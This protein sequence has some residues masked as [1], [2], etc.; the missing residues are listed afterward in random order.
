MNNDW[1][2]DIE[3]V[4]EKIRKNSSILSEEHKHTYFRLKNTLQY[5][6]LPLI[7]I[8]GIN[9][10]ISVG[11]QQYLE[12]PTISG[13]TCVL[14]LI[15]SII[16]SIEL[17]LAI[18]KRVEAELISSREYYLLT[19]DIQKT[20]LLNREH[21]PLPAKEYLE[22]I[23][24][25]YIKLTESSNLVKKSIKDALSEVTITPPSTPTRIQSVLGTFRG[26]ES[27]DLEWGLSIV[28]P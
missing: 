11:L 4:L 21:R 25:T 1:T 5:F 14:S 28:H 6:R 24:N 7:V 15:C 17:F 20:L 3:N 13:I 2:E 12:Q 22:K 19:I 27:G 23:Y 9:S 16:G 10:V 8:S 26:T 18:Q